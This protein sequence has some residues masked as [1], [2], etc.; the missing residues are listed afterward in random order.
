MS[1]VTTRNVGYAGKIHDLGAAVSRQEGHEAAWDEL[2]ALGAIVN[3]SPSSDQAAADEATIANHTPPAEPKPLTEQSFAEL[4]ATA[5]AEGVKGFG[6][7]KDD[8]KLREAIEAHRAANP[9][10]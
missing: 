3:G 2:L 6:Q 1:H 7:I 5:K 8:A 9:A 4:K 10:A